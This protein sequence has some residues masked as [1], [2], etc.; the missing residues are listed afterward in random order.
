MLIEQIFESEGPG[1]PGRTCTSITGCFNYKTI[2]CTENIRL[3]YYLLLKYRR[4]QCTLRR[5]P[6]PG[7]NHLQN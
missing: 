4:R 5:L 6:L 2:I 3:D 1:S 7:P